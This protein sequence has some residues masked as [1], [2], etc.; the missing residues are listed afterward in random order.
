MMYMAK[1]DSMSHMRQGCRCNCCMW[2]RSATVK[3]ILAVMFL[4]MVM[5]LAFQLVF[6]A[7]FALQAATLGFLGVI[8]LIVAV[9]WIVSMAC[10]C[11][12]RHWIH[13][14]DEDPIEV[15][16]LRYAKG[17]IN[18]TDYERIVKTVSR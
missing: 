2:H 7:N 11:K 6:G 1:R 10:S 13:G 8:F 15:A 9:G 14:P 12:G 3:I 4:A 16:R 5:S 17:E 18:K